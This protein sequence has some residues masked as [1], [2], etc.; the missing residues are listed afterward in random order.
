MTKPETCGDCGYFAPTDAA[1]GVCHRRAPGPLS[2]V[3]SARPAAWACWPLVAVDD[4]C[5]E[6][7]SHSETTVEPADD[8]A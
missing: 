3:D 4:W 2:S 1:H 8:P 6:F 5:G 7:K